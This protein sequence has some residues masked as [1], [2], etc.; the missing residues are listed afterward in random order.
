MEIT[1]GRPAVN[2]FANISA[3]AWSKGSRFFPGCKMLWISRI[4]QHCWW[5]RGQ[6]CL[7][8][9]WQESAGLETPALQIA[10]QGRRWII[11]LTNDEARWAITKMRKS[12]CRRWVCRVNVV[13]TF[14]SAEHFP[15]RKAQQKVFG[16]VSINDS[17]MRRMEA[18]IVLTFD[19]PFTHRFGSSF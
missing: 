6:I 5:C 12:F 13:S 1:S 7:H 11:S 15:F 18:L 8:G 10:P 17:A 2:R 3:L 14:F 4:D 16:M 19:E 9:F